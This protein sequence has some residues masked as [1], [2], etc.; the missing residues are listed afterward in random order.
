MIF[1]VKSSLKDKIKNFDCAIIKTGMMGAMGNKGSCLIRF[2]YLDSSFAF[3]CGHFAAGSSHNKDRVNELSE[4]LNKTFPFNK[5]TR[6]KD[7]NIIFIMGDLNFRIDL[8]YDGCVKLINSR[9]LPQLLQ[10]DQFLKSKEVNFN[11]VDIEEGLI[12]FNPTYKYVQG[13]QEYDTKKKR[14]PSWCD[15][16]LYKKSKF[17]T[18][19]AYDRA[20]YTHSDHRPIFSIFNVFA[21]KELKDKKM[22]LINEIKQ[23]MVLGIKQGFNEDYDNANSLKKSFM[24]NENVEEK[25]F[26]SSKFYNTNDYGVF[27]DHYVKDIVEKDD[28]EIIHFF[29]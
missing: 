23:N 15:R 13:S 9:N 5:D 2:N 14:V 21:V 3:S 24:Y 22:G 4:I 10:Y 16:I 8:D 28:N 12:T 1:F 20:E 27:E 25:K 6:F 29:K 18:Q 7:H 26:D 17:I 11:L 19:V